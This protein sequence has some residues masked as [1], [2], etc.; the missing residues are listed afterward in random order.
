V[1]VLKPHRNFQTTTTKESPQQHIHP[2]HAGIGD[3]GHF[4]ISQ[5][6]AASL[7]LQA[8]FAQK[9]DA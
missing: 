7:I 9:E 8:F 5:P 3:A 4:V 2:C 1:N 6:R